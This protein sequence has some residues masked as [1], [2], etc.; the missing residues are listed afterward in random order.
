MNDRCDSGAK[1]GAL[2]LDSGI[3][4]IPYFRHFRESNPGIPCAYLADRAHFP[5]GG[6]EG[7]ELRAILL[8]LVNKIITIINPEII[9]LACNTA[10]IAAL[11]ALREAFPALPF[12]G[13]V[14][15]VK[16]ATAA[17]KSGKVCVLGTEF[18]VS[19]SCLS[20][21]KALYEN[22][23]IIG[24]AAPELVRF[25][26]NSMASAD[27]NARRQMAR[28]YLQRMRAQGIDALVLG[29][30]H[31]LLLLDEFKA[32]ARPDI[33]VFESVRGI[34]SRVE[35][36]LKEARGESA[37]T[38]TPPAQGKIFLTGGAPPEPSW[39]A[40]AQALGCGLSLLEPE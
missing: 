14:P 19:E 27:E 3:G 9:V 8:E 2:F 31:F 1:R 4:G 34:S 13:T 29:C 12:V 39:A 23:E 16:P 28:S 38:E 30:T 11:G 37:R 21:F 22:S 32:E 24:M 6:R 35:F 20:D 5:Y 10:S 40:L 17:S 25:V 36:L 33:T 15:A 7:A 26:E 18:T